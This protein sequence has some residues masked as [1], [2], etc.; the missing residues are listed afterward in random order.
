MLTSPH[1]APAIAPFV[2]GQDSYK[3][4]FRL[5]KIRMLFDSYKDTNL[6]EK[7]DEEQAYSRRSLLLS[8]AMQS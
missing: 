6:I 2:R 4:I 3:L 7:E 1:E 8:R 5:Q